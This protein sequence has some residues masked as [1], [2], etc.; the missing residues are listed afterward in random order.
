MAMLRKPVSQKRKARSANRA[1]TYK[2]R[3]VQVSTKAPPV[4]GV[5]RFGNYGFPD[6]VSTKMIYGDVVQLN[7]TGAQGFNY[8]TFRLNSLFDPDYTGVGHQPQWFDQYASVYK[9]YRVKGSKITVTFMPCTLD[10]GSTNTVGPYFVGATACNASGL[11]ATSVASLTED[12]NGSQGILVAKNGGNK[13][14]VTN[15]YSPLRD[16][17][18]DAYDNDLQAVTSSNPNAPWF[19]HVFAKD[20]FGGVA[21]FVMAHVKIEFQAEFFNRIEGVLS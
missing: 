2:K 3:R 10:P 19:C 9:N 11:N 15:T 7:L 14:V 16:L 12:I 1:L 20:M 21:S 18:L 5:S 6:R 13:V 4:M 17:G 8:W